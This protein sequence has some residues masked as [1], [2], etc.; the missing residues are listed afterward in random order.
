MEELKKLDIK[1]D[2]LQFE[3]QNKKKKNILKNKNNKH[4]N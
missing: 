4:L 3:K 1:T 2:P